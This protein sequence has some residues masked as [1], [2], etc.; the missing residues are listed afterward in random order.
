[1]LQQHLEHVEVEG[2]KTFIESPSVRS[3]L[4]YRHTTLGM[5]NEKHTAPLINNTSGS[6]IFERTL[7]ALFT[8]L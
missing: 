8:A 2:Y 3:C 5:E 1:M 7:D 6:R 4:R